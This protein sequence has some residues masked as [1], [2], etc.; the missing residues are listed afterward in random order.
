MRIAIVGSGISGNVAA[1][2]LATAHDVTLF[3]AGDYAGGHANT[4]DVEVGG[5]VF[6]VDTGFMVFNERTYPNFCRL[7]SMLDVPSQDSDMSFSVR[8]ERTGWEYQGSS[9]NGLF[10]QRRN[11]V[12]PAFLNMLRD[13]RRFNRQAP[14]DVAAGRFGRATLGEYLAARRYGRRFVEQYLVPMT[15]A[16]WSARPEEIYQFPLHFLV[17]FFRNHGLLQLRDRPQWKTI[18]GGS[19]VYVSALLAPL[20]DRVRLRT[21]V[22]CVTRSDFHVVVKPAAEA[23]EIF[24]HVVFATHADQTLKLLTDATAPEREILSAF[25]YQKNDAVLHTDTRLL[26]R[27]RRAWASWNYHVP[28]EDD[29]PPTVTYDLS[30]LQR[31]GSREPILLTLNEA[32]RVRPEK[33]LRRFTY[34]HPAYRWESVRAQDRWAEISGRRRTHFCGAYWGYG[35]HEDG[36][37]SALAVA[38]HFGIALND[39]LE[40]GREP[41]KVASMKVAS[42]TGAADL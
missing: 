26:P 24:D 36:V 10:A 33:I 16:I 18:L 12:R 38:K 9:L 28:R 22:Q 19:R 8:C 25:P 13:I 20:G 30:R 42:S 35:F 2:L 31:H 37:S 41:C 11:A 27:R 29:H 21:P 15:S 4:V 40:V 5:S 7:L 34:D 32:H 17:G 23:A 3:E 39:G 6:P 14:R 1:R